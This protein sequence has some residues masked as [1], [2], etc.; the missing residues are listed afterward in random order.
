MWH[1]RATL[2]SLYG[3]LRTVP[4][5]PKF[6]ENARGTRVYE[7]SGETFEPSIA[8]PQGVSALARLLPPGFLISR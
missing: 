4:G 5:T 2:R 3:Q 8:H 1:A 6:A 7:E